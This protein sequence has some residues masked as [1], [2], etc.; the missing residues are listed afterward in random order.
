M[1]I[2]D[3]KNMS[4]SDSINRIVDLVC[5]WTL[6]IPPLI[7]LLAMELAPAIIHTC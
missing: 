4:A 3:Y 5:F 1:S 6:R 7:D 2:W